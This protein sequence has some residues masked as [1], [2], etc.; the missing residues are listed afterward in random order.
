MNPKC[1]K[2]AIL[3]LTYLHYEQPVKNKAARKTVYLLLL[4]FGNMMSVNR[5]VIL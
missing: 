4:Y 5:R 1:Y 2:S 3:A